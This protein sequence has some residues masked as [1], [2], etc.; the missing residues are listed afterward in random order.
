[1]SPTLAPDTM[2]PVNVG[3]ESRITKA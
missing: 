3:F 1:M 2:R